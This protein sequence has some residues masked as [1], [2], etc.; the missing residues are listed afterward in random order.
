MNRDINEVLAARRAEKPGLISQQAKELLNLRG[1]PAMLNSA[2]TAVL[3]GL[4]E[5]DIPVLVRSGVLQPLGDP[6][7]NAVKAFATTLVLELAGE[8]AAL[9]KIRTVVYEYWRTKNAHR[10]DAGIKPPP[11]RNGHH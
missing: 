9:N 5:H 3:L 4:A 8:V 2:Q 11:T 10:T 1:L 6:P 7:P